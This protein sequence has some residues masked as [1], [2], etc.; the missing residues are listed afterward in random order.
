MNQNIV[1]RA[2]FFGHT[3]QFYYFQFYYLGIN[4]DDAKLSY[5]VALCI[6]FLHLFFQLS[7]RHDR[8]VFR[9]NWKKRNNNK[10]LEKV[11]PK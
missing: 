7:L 3:L 9:V 4:E 5:E 8:F 2:I 11:I 6:T 1:F 10:T